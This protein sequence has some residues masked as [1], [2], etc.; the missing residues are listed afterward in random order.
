M[1]HYDYP[2]VETQETN[3]KEPEI[4]R[5]QQKA[6]IVSTPRVVPIQEFT[7]TQEQIDLIKRMHQAAGLTDDEFKA[8]LHFCRK[9]RVDPLLKQAYATKRKMKDG[10]SVVAIMTSIEGLRAIADRTKEY[11]PGGEPEFILGEKNKLI[12]AKVAVKKFV[13]G[14]WHEFKGIAYFSEFDQG[15][16]MWNKMPFNQLAKCA[17]A[18]A[19]RKGWP[20]DCGGFY[21]PEEFPEIQINGDV[22]QQPTKEKGKLGKLKKSASEN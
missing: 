22:Q 1:G 13:Q 21:V 6:E 16:F 7:F 17:E 20:E 15:N 2:P 8:F 14:E 19:L 9:K 18:Q 10:S 11:C 12:A 5:P 3:I 4:M